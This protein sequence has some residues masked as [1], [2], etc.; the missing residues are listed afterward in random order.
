MSSPQTLISPQTAAVTAKAMFKITDAR[1]PCTL[2]ANNLASA[3]EVDV[4]FSV[5]G[6]A[7]WVLMQSGGTAVKLTATT[8]YVTFTTPMTIGVVKDA[9]AGACGVYM[10]VADKV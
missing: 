4:Y 1:I 7:T 3:E 5:D 2:I 10:A 9:T 6:G 8:P